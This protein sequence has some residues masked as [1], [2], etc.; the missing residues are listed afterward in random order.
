[1]KL[2]FSVER[3]I[4]G[5]PKSISELWNVDEKNKECSQLHVCWNEEIRETRAR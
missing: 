4:N 2:F 3:V 1:M 5:Q